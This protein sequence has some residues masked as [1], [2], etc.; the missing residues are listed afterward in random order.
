MDD[1]TAVLITGITQGSI[2][3]LLALGIVLLQNATGVVN[4][5]HGDLMTLGAYIGF[6][7]LV[8]HHTP[9]L[10]MYLLMM[11]AMAVVGVVLER[12]GYAPLRGRPVITIVISTFALGLAIRGALVAWHGA[13]PLNLPSPFGN[14]VVRIGDVPITY[15][16]ILIVAVM[17][18][19][20]GVLF[21]AFQRTSLG[22]QVRALAADQETAQLQGIRIRRLSPAIFALSAVLAGLAG[23]L[24]APVTAVTPFLGFNLLLS[25]FAAVVIGG[26]RLG[27]S[28]IAAMVVALAQA[29]ATTWISPDF[30]DAYPF[31]ILVVVL[32]IRPQGLVKV[33][34]GVRY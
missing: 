23:V 31:L 32:A 22:R 26:E 6:F 19:L 12:L 20:T 4:F 14:D 34:S 5:A 28:V 30:S 10:V 21:W 25:A 11:V 18:V 2:F 29:A 7:L 17:F 24:V 33:I 3:A 9:Q 16:A 1:L 13:D 8:D 15:Q 27:G